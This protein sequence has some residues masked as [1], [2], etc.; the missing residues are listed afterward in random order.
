MARMTLEL[1]QSADSMLKELCAVTGQPA[2][3]LASGAVAHLH[4]SLIGLP[5]TD[6]DAP[7]I[8]TG[9]FRKRYSYQPAEVVLRQVDPT[10]FNLEEPFQYL[11]DDGNPLWVV[12]ATDVT[13][14]ASTPGFLTW[15]VPRYGRHT[16]AALLHDHL[17]DQN[18]DHPVSS[19]AADTVFRDAMADTGVPLL[20]RWIMWTAV[21]ARTRKNLGGI[22]MITVILWLGLYGMV[23]CI[24]LPALVLAVAAGGLSVGSALGLVALALVS[25]FVLGLVWWHG[26]RFAVIAGVT[27]LFIG[28]AALLDVVV[29]GIYAG[30]ETVTRPFQ[31]H[32]VPIRSRKLE[33]HQQQALTPVSG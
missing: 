9:P 15:L 7:K 19:A 27:T 10:N 25:P 2:A 28:Y 13:D 17:Q 24:G 20:L 6:P 16:L 1:S 29:Y 14:L 18:I 23:G 33:E 31:K 26:Y 5:S 12:P 11:D 4:R 8:D 30:F 21:S 3:E 22:S 32:P